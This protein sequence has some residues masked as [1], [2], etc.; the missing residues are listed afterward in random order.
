[1]WGSLG[2]TKMTRLN[3]WGHTGLSLSILVPCRQIRVL[4]GY[5]RGRGRE[6]I[7]PEGFR[8]R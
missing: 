5:L 2:S 8:E 3:S 7:N 6:E 4:A 1:M